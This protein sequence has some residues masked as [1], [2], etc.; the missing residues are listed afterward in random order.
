MVN[1]LEKELKL[2]IDIISKFSEEEFRLKNHPDKWSKKE[3]LGHLI[4]SAV[5]NLQRFTEVEFSNQPYNVR[6]YN[7][8]ELV[9]TNDYQNSETK[10]L[11]NFWLAINTRIQVIIKKQTNETLRLKF[12]I[13]ND[14][15]VDFK[16]LIK[17]YIDHLVHHLRQIEN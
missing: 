10:E 7:Q 8:N 16:F 3:I 1:N 12:Q 9:K 13:D 15:V 17:D 2:G 4:D 6:K 11:L 5:N 14:T